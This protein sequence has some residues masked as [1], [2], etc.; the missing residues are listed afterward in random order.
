MRVTVR[1]G[2]VLC[3][4]PWGYQLLVPGPLWERLDPAGRLSILRHELAHAE[5]GDVWKSL[6]VRLLALPHW[7]NPLAWWAVRRF[8][9]AAE[10]ACDQAVCGASRQARPEYA[11]ALVVMGET[12]AAPACS[13][14]RLAAGSLSVFDG[15]WTPNE[16][17]I[18]S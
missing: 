6:G 15:S 16:G 1:I 18:L 13:G 11:K 12:A 3:R 14:R 5:R 9:E 2:P 4:L 10:W 17:R 8:D 7:F